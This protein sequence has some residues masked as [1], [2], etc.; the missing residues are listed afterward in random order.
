MWCGVTVE[1]AAEHLHPVELEGREVRHCNRLC[2]QWKRSSCPLVA[3]ACGSSSLSCMSYTPSPSGDTP[4]HIDHAIT[5]TLMC[6]C[7]LAPH[8]LQRVTWVCREEIN[9]WPSYSWRRVSPVVALYRGQKRP[10][11]C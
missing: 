9:V 7:F 3:Q 8:R 2:V 1:F 6:I 11:G 4:P 10:A 5:L